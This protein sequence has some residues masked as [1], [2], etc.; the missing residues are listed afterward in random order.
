MLTH[1]S[2]RDVVLVD[3]VERAIDLART[4][5]IAEDAI[6]VTGSLYIVGAARPHLRRVLR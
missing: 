3:T 2:I 1:L 5:A 4:D 6:L